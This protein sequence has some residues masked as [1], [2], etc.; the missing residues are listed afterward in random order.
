MSGWGWKEKLECLWGAS[1]QALNLT[2]TEDLVIDLGAGIT[3]VNLSRM[4]VR[5]PSD[6]GG[7]ARRGPLP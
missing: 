3:R 6:A 5:V 7:C 4:S 2:L 1:F